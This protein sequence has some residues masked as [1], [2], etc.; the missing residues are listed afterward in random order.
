MRRNPSGAKTPTF[1]SKHFVVRSLNPDRSKIWIEPPTRHASE[2]WVR[3]WISQRACHSASSFVWK[4]DFSMTLRANG[5]RA[6]GSTA[7]SCTRNTVPMAPWPR[8]LRALRLSRF[9]SGEDGFVWNSHLM[10]PFVD[11][12]EM[13]MLKLGSPELEI[14][15]AMAW[16]LWHNLDEI[17]LRE[18]ASSVETVCNTMVECY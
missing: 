9:S 15:F 13:T 14:S 8:T 10:V 3:T 16:L 11:F 4:E 2:S 12:V 5:Q 6:E 18:T 7:Q 1:R 17:G